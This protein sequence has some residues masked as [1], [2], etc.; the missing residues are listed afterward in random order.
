[1]PYKVFATEEV[2]A[3]ADVMTYLMKQSV[4]TC[5]SGTRPGSPNEGMTIYETD[6][7]K[8]MGHDGSAWRELLA[9]NPP[10]ACAQRTSD[11]SI[12]S[13]VQ[14]TVSFAQISYNF[15]NMW[16]IGNPTRLTVPSGMGGIYEIGG[17]IEYEPNINGA[18]QAILLVNGAP[19]GRNSTM[20]S[21]SGPPARVGFTR[22][23]A[24]SAG[25]YVELAGYQNSGVT[26]QMTNASRAPELWAR[27]VRASS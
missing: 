17:L 13:A 27:R 3:S 8:Y 7:D 14:T 18:R 9:I 23:I 19:V 6:T 10:A 2:L 16:S 22:D 11:Q 24:L 5:T 1:V 25:D 15:R 12:S 4:I 26:L 20:N 21:G